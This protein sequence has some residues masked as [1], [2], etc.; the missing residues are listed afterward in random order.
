MIE[1]AQSSSDFAVGDRVVIDLPTSPGLHGK[2]G[3]IHSPYRGS[4]LAS[5]WVLVDGY[6]AKDG[7]CW[8]KPSELRKDG[9][10]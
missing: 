4:T 5:W 8:F 9:G 2:G 6:A 10:A 1:P 7:P 3:V